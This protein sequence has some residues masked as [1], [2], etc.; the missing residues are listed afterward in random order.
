[1]ELLCWFPAMK[2]EPSIITKQ[3]NLDI[4][5]YFRDLQIW[6]FFLCAWV[7]MFIFILYDPI[8]HSCFPSTCGLFKVAALCSRSPKLWMCF[9]VLNHLRWYVILWDIESMSEIPFLFNAVFCFHYESVI[10]PIVCLL[11][12]LTKVIYD[13]KEL[14]FWRE[15][16]ICQI[17]WSIIVITS[18]LFK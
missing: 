17:N 18:Q 5:G 16:K 14:S 9:V 15:F 6:A 12:S 1:M 2:S 7:L 13:L 4:S 11:G 8:L 10:I 3:R